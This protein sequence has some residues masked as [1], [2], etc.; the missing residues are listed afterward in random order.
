VAGLSAAR[1]ACLA[2]LA[3]L[4]RLACRIPAFDRRGS[5]QNTARSIYLLCRLIDLNF[6]FHQFYATR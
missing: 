5:Q 6:L 4:A 3:C 2:C 1:V